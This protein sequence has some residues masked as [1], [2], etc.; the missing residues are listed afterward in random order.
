MIKRRAVIL[1][2]GAALAV[3]AAGGFFLRPRKGLAVSSRGFDWKATDFLSGGTGSVPATLP[4]PVFRAEPNCIATCAKT[5]GPCHVSDVPLRTDI[6][7]G[8]IGLPVRLSLR[9][10]TAGDCAPVEGAE[11]EIWHANAKGVY[12]GRAAGMCSP[13][14]EAAKASLAFR[15][16]QISDA[17]GR[18]DF[19]TVYPGW[20]DGRTV[21][22]HM[23]ILVEGRELLV[24]QLLFDDA[25]SDLVY[26]AHPD[27]AGRSERRTKNGNDGL[28]SSGEVGGYL[29]DVEMLE[30]G[31]LQAAYTIGVSPE[32]NNC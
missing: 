11:V 8:Q 13:G 21:H 20:Y 12:S 7:E 19:V 14:D 18:V 6:S 4:D 9:I 5:L 31:V 17:G 15:G 16:R 28:F 32:G 24:S 29:F 30:P 10:V 2:G 25:L 3:A 27:Y 23:R 26:D 22:V 1:G